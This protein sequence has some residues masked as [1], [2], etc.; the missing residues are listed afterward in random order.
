MSILSSPNQPL[1]TQSPAGEQVAQLRLQGAGDRAVPQRRARGQR[2]LPQVGRQ[3]GPTSHLPQV[4]REHQCF[5]DIKSEWNDW[6]NMASQRTFIK[7]GIGWDLSQEN[8]KVTVPECGDCW[9][10]PRGDGHDPSIIHSPQSVLKPRRAPHPLCRQTPSGNPWTAGLRHSRPIQKLPLPTSEGDL[11]QSLRDRSPSHSSRIPVKGTQFGALH[12]TGR[13]SL[14]SQLVKNTPAMQETWVQSL[15]W[16]D[17]LEKG[18]ATCSS[19]L[20]W[21]IP[22]TVE[23]LGP[24][25]VRQD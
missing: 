17:P 25:R 15:G 1:E 10:R 14:M 19:I 7:Q 4:S 5:Q 24:Q 23:S 18:M 12:P 6:P 3:P 22:W 2:E 8:I 20:A 21:R 13:V 9:L 11:Q 16:E